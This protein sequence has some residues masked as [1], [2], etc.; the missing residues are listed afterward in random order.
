MDVLI[1]VLQ[2]FILASAW[3][4][5]TY[6]KKLPD[7]IHAKNLK[8]FEHDLNTQMEILRNQW[9]T[10]LELLKINES[11]LHIHKTEEFSKL[12]KILIL[13]MLDKKYMRKLAT[14]E[15]TKE[16]FNRSMLDLGTK[17][18]FFASDSTVKKFV[19][20]RKSG[21]DPAAAAGRDPKHVLILLAELMLE[22]RKDLG[23]KDTEC[24]TDD[25]L[26]IMIKDWHRY[27]QNLG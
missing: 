11:Q 21:Q 20:W 5:Y 7:Q 25:Y 2:S 4:L 6:F 1:I 14:D 16:E 9:T 12:V 23:Y 13:N 26:Y 8:V 17:L 10:D 19:E 22:V 15:K 18:F 24:T 3:F 27:D